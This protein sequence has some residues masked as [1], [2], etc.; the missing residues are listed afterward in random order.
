LH[1]RLRNCHRATETGAANFLL[2][3]TRFVATKQQHTPTP[4]ANGRF[5]MRKT[6]EV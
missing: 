4:F 5:G 3:R 2:H 6:T 1:L